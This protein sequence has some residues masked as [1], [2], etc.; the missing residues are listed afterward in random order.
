MKFLSRILLLPL[1]LAAQVAL[2]QAE[3]GVRTVGGVSFNLPAPKGFCVADEK[4]PIDAQFINVVSSLLSGAKNKLIMTTV[5]CGSLTKYRNRAL[6]RLADY[7][8]YYT[9]YQVENV[10]L[11][12]S[13]A[14]MR[15]EFCNAMRKQGNSTLDGVKDI[16]AQKAKELGQNFGV[17]STSYIGVL[18]EDEHGCYSAL[19]VG[20]SDGSGHTTIMSAVITSTVIRSKAIFL[21]YYAEYVSPETTTS[22]V[23]AAKMTAA[24]LDAKNK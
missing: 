3:S 10:T 6:D 20:V 9:P 11:P 22:G 17:N 12:G 8:L 18:D 16:V 15:K 14:A 21:A 24:E 5:D 23:Q 2:A 19:L 1:A 7:A 13:D 4:H